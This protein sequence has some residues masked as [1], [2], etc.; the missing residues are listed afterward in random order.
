MHGK[1]NRSCTS[2]R[3][4]RSSLISVTI[5]CGIVCLAFPN[6]WKTVRLRV[7]DSASEALS[8]GFSI[9][10][11]EPT[12]ITRRSKVSFVSNACVVVEQARY[13]KNVGGAH[14][15]HWVAV[16]TQLKCRTSKLLH[17]E[18]IMQREAQRN[19]TYFLRTGNATRGNCRQSDHFS[20]TTRTTR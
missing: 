8:D 6:C 20:E 14:I 13:L 1:V 15:G 2:V 16:L 12:S 7:N 18:A 10:Q 5:T 4:L 3:V 9:F 11:A 19:C 17:A